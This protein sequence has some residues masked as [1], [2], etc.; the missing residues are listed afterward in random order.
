MR[1]QDF[2]AQETNLAGATGDRRKNATV[3]V[4]VTCNWKVAPV[5]EA[6][7]LSY[8]V[9]FLFSFIWPAFGIEY[10]FVG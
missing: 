5:E 9:I 4:N 6:G 10:Y 2:S 7:L 3:Q 1:P 8:L